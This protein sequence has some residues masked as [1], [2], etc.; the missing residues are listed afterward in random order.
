MVGMLFFMFSLSVFDEGTLFDQLS[1]FF[2]QNIPTAIL[3]ALIFLSKRY[4]KIGGAILIIIWLFFVFFF[5]AFQNLSLF[6][7]LIPVLIAGILFL[8]QHKFTD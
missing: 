8:F 5:N 7:M 2:M 4:P 3:I 6:I 1:G